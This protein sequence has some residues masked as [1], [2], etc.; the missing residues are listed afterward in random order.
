MEES[1]GGDTTVKHQPRLLDQVR[2]ASRQKHFSPKT[3]KAF[4]YW[5]RQFMLFNNRRHP[6]E[7]EKKEIEVYL[8]HLV[9]RQR[10]T[11]WM[12]SSF[13]S[14]I[15]VLGVEYLVYQLTPLKLGQLSFQPV[16]YQYQPL[17]LL[18]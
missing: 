6:K 4:V 18:G 1:Y 11:S 10:S 14:L 15:T 3:E 8:N 2:I 13:Y 17:F 5:I 7:M 9:T 16:T 12:K